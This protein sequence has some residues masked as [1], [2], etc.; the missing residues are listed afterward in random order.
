[1]FHFNFTDDS[2]A[3]G[4]RDLIFKCSILK[5]IVVITSIMFVIHLGE[6]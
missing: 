2:S 3:S 1:M 4:E 5:C 6:S